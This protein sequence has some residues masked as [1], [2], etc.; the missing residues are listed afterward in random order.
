M[1]FIDKVCKL[2]EGSFAREAVIEMI[3]LL[4][5]DLPTCPRESK[6]KGRTT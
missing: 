6:P 1:L 5:S 4:N 3:D 2:S